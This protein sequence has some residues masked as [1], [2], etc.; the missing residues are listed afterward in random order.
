MNAD[1]TAAP[2][3][4]QPGSGA[5]GRLIIH[6]GMQKTGTT[7]L[8]TGMNTHREA[9][10]ARGLIY[11]EPL[12]GMG[13]T[14]PTAH[15]F[16]AHALMGRRFGH[17]P[18]PDFSRLGD[19]AAA[20]RAVAAQAGGTAV[21]SSEDL[22]LLRLPQI[23]QLRALFPDEGVQILVYLRRQDLWLESLYGQLL[24]LGRHQATAAF[25]A[26][27]RRRMDYAGVLAPWATVF[28]AKNLI[29]RTYEGFE[30]GGL[31]ADF[32]TAVGCPQAADVVPEGTRVNVSLSREASTFLTRIRGDRL[33]HWARQALERSHARGGRPSLSYL[34]PRQARQIME[35]H[36]AGNDAVASL[37]LGRAHL[38]R[39]ET[40]AP[41]Q[42]RL[43]RPLRRAI[44][45]WRLVSGQTLLILD[46]LR[47]LKPRG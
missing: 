28:G 45:G 19:H 12:A 31:W 32:C 29:V 47:S 17:T 27:N 1:T 33:R 7:F 26:R 30:G 2:D 36:R 43:P 46:R 6:I 22:S 9:L 14:G 10:A 44:V 5:A 25:A 23:R 13:G 35:E 3:R 15:H 8:Q 18:G 4:T 38:F 37:Y 42:D 20:L 21:L 24:K 11:S 41:R 39:D 34:T 40:A 16:L